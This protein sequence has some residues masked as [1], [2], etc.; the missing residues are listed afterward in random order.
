MLLRW[1]PRSVSRDDRAGDAAIHSGKHTLGTWGE[2]VTKN[3]AAAGN[4][5]ADKSVPRSMI[6]A[7][8]L[9]AKFAKF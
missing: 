7:F 5:L 8:G 9:F 4:L 2:A 1:R 6:H 3:A